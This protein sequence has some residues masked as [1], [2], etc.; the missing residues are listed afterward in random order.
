MAEDKKEAL[1][2]GVNVEGDSSPSAGPRDRFHL[3]YWF[4]FL[5]GV[6]GMIPWDVLVSVNGYWKHK[7]R[8]TS[9]DDAGYLPLGENST[10]TT[11]QMEMQSYIGMTASLPS[12]IVMNFNA[13]IG[14]RFTVHK[15]ALVGLVRIPSNSTKSI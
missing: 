8:N 7:L 15:K 6:V 10:L 5:A 12:L 2:F 3:I 13:A 4:A 11:L 9:L 1:D 14:T